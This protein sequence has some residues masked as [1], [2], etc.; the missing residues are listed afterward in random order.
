MKRIG[1]VISVA[2]AAVFSLLFIGCEAESTADLQLDLIP[3][4][5]TL[6]H[7]ESVVFTVYGGFDYRWSLS[8]DTI[9]KLNTRTGNQV[10]YTDTSTNSGTQFLTVQSYIIGASGSSPTNIVATNQPSTSA[11]ITA[12]IKQLGR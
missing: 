4:S 5:A 9:G 11:S 10:I 12:T 8:D 6:S 1:L 3:R 7:G 2:F